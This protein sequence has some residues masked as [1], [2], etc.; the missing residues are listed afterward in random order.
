MKSFV[1]ASALVFFVVSVGQAQTC[2]GPTCPQ[3]TILQ[4]VST[5]VVNL[6]RSA[7]PVNIS[8]PNRQVR[9]GFFAR[10]VNFVS[11]KARGGRSCGSCR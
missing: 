1:L 2:S 5:P 11:P 7:N 8:A 9:Q 3:P 4:T 10:V 6:V